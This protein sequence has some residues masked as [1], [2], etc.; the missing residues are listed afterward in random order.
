MFIP[1]SIAISTVY[2]AD[3]AVKLVCIEP[4]RVHMKLIFWAILA[5]P[6]RQM[7]TIEEKFG[8]HTEKVKTNSATKVET[9]KLLGLENTTFNAFIIMFVT[10]ALFL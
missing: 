9:T 10:G 4:Y 1:K 5:D 7:V 6:E 2:V 3:T 8:S